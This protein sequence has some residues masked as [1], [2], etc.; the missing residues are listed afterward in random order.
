MMAGKREKID[1]CL[2]KV[3]SCGTSVV[4]DISSQTVLFHND[5]SNRIVIILL[6]LA[7]V[8]ICVEHVFCWVSTYV[9]SHLL[10]L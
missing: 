10:T 6:A 8:Y 2:Q 7:G 1:H 5:F 4:F 9:F 3:L